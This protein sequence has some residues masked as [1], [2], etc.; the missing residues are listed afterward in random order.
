MKKRAIVI[1]AVLL[2]IT[3]LNYSRL[4]ADSNTR[5]VESLSSFAIGVLTGILILQVALVIKERKK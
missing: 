5:T 3:I 1:T 2:V 4:V